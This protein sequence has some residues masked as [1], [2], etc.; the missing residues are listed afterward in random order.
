MDW[1]RGNYNF[2][3]IGQSVTILSMG[4]CECNCTNSKALNEEELQ[5]NLGKDYEGVEEVHHYHRD[6]KMNG[7]MSHQDLF[8]RECF[9]PMHLM[10][11]KAMFKM[12]DEMQ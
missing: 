7:K 12:I 5:L 11:V 8:F 3:F 1:L 6:H 4:G 9:K 2:E 10:K